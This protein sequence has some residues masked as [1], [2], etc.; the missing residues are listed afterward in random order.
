[1][2]RFY[3]RQD[4]AP[5]GFLA[6][7][8]I[9]LHCHILSGIDDG[10]RS[11]EESI[12]IAGRF[13]AAGI[14]C[15]IATPHI[16]SDFFLNTKS[17][18]EVAWENLRPHLKDR[19]PDM[20]LQFAAEYYADD[21]FDLLLDKNEILP[22]SGRYVLVE[23]SMIRD[24]PFFKDI[25]RRMTDKGWIPV[26][27]HPE[28]Y[29]A[30]HGNESRYAEFYEMN[31]IFQVNLMSLGG[32]YGPREQE[33]AEK[34]VQNGWV[35]AVGSDLHQLKNFQYLESAFNN[36]VYPRLFEQPLLNLQLLRELGNE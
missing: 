20:Q 25:I 34:L 4:E 32:R 7:L 24:E 13:Y 9:D 21:Y 29:R 19:F 31:V 12:A 33:M 3:E 30:W 35:G 15:I 28:R 10:A 6:P 27:A 1:M 36:P 18:I 8:G 14:R 16:R 23:T 22:L 2:G 11:L 5:A 17:S 26:I